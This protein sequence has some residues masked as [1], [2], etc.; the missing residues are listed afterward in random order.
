MDVNCTKCKRLIES[1]NIN[2]EKD[3]AFCTSCRSLSS[4]SSMLVSATDPNF[5]SRKP[6]SGTKVSRNGSNWMIS[7][8][9][10][11]FSA[12]FFVPFTVV[13]AGGSMTGIYGTQIAEGKFSLSQ[14]LF[15]LPFLIGSIVLITL[16]LMSIFGRTLVSVENNKA[17]VFIGIGAIGWYRRF[18]WRDV[19]KVIETNKG[20][21]KYISL[22]GSKRLN[23]GWGLSA[24][25][26]FYLANFLRT[27]LRA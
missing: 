15:G 27:K 10:R 16:C 22:E 20:Q 17:L 5:D 25:K 11:S 6:V 26:Q 8:S 24:S 2:V 1:K 21:Q 14:S 9:H 18:E 4:L 13:W 3:T 12:L 19:S 7:A 23:L